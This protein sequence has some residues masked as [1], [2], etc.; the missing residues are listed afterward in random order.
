MSLN[1]TRLTGALG[2]TVEGVKLDDLDNQADELRQA[3]A[4][5]QVLVFPQIGMDPAEQLALCAVFGE[6]EPHGVDGDDTRSPEYADDDRL[7]TVIN[8]HKAGAHIWHTDATFRDHPPIG[9]LLQLKEK[10]DAGGD[11]MWASTTRA[12]ETLAGPLQ[13]MCREL[14]AEH[15]RPGLTGKAVHPVITTHPVTGDEILFVNRGWTNHLRGLPHLQGSDLLELL[16]NHIERP[17]HTMRWTWQ[18]GDAVL[19]DNRCTQHY[20]I[21]DYGEHPRSGHRV[22]LKNPAG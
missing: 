13:D 17:E 9:A 14:E 10:P 1:I 5:H 16:Y 3:W 20:A 7:I 19:W 18:I 21:Y 15:G 6:P 2:A 22:I 11:T 8:S 12:F 4:D